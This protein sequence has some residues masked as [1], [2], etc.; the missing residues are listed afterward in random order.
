MI[1][2]IVLA[3]AV[4]AAVKI[5]SV[6]SSEGASPRLTHTIARG[7]LVV[8][9]TSQGL[10]ESS[11]NTEIKCQVRGRNAVLWIVESGTTVKPGDELVRIDPL[12]LQEQIDERTK[13]AHWSQS[14]ADR[15]AATVARSILAVSEYEEGRYLNEVMIQEKDLVIAEAALKTAENRLSHTKVMAKS[16]YISEL[17]VEEKEFAVEQAKLS[18]ELKRTQ[19]DVLKR[20]TKKE[21]SQTLSGELKAIKATHEANAERAMAD[22]SRRDRAL[23]EVQ[24]CVVKAPRGGLVIHPNAAS[25][26]SGPIAEGTRVY[27]DQVMLLMPDLSRMQVKVGINESVVDR[28]KVGQNASVKL[29]DM[30]LEGTVSSVASITKPAGWWTANEV[31]YDTTISLPAGH[32]LRPGMSAEAEV[33]I[34][35]YEDIL[36]IPV[37]A[38]VEAGDDHFCWVQTA[39]GPK[40]RPIRIGDSNGIFTV[41]EQ[42][43]AEGDEVILN[44][45]A[46]GEPE[47]AE[48]ASTETEESVPDASP[49]EKKPG[50]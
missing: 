37:A 47:L 22:A 15:S 26:E 33:I 13:Y 44:P 17:E 18:V 6:M 50:K 16:R 34:A 12:F 3:G 24:H 14:A 11:E 36:T 38:I 30:T 41:V 4:A 10:V 35:S 9:V 21:Q 29:A 23:A 45:V 25:W 27:K 8:T 7:D 5:S 46:F 48:S 1:A 42:G 40:R 31:N 43:L 19:L 39:D 20:F 28:V 49:V 32:G 2:L